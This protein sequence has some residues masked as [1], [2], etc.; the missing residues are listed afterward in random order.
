MPELRR[1]AAKLVASLRHHGPRSTLRA[2]RRFAARRVHHYREAAVDRRHGTD[3]GG[4]IPLDE[5]DIASPNVEH[6]VHFE[7]VTRAYFERMLA[8]A[9]IERPER[10]TFVDL[11]CGKGR[12]L[13][14]AAEQ[15]FARLVGV[16]FSAALASI[17]EENVRRYVARTGEPNRFDIRHEDAADFVFPAGPI[18]LFL[19]NPF[20]KAVLGKVIENLRAAFAGEPRDVAVLYRTPRLAHLFAELPFLREVAGDGEFRVFR[21]TSPAA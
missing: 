3:S 6:G 14:F 13:L 2:L 12:A 10:F 9:D 18:A 19:Y 21:T 20:G 7:P 4:F 17:A 15:P 8:A 5:L 1:L 11:G 16:E